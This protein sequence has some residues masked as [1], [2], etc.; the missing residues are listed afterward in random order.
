VDSVPP[1]R[2]AGDRSAQPARTND[3]WK[4]HRFVIAV[5]W[6]LVIM[7]LCWLPRD[8]VQEV[9]DQSSWFEL[10]HLDKI[11]HCGI[12]V[13]FSILWLRVRSNRRPVGPVVLSG[14]ALAA[15]TEIVQDL[16]LIGRDSSIADTL[17]DVIGVLIG[18]AVAP[19]IEPVA[20]SLESR[21]FRETTP[22]PLPAEP[23]A[24]VTEASP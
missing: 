22:G 15:L 8:L 13:V 1:V 18:V 11:V 21:L 20:R 2:N 24:A 4:R 12:F 23:A 7:L 5:V 16:P 9:E 17:T 6:T 19:L 10:P 14:F 3:G